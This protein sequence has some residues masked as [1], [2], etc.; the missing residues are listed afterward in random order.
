[1]FSIPSTKTGS[2]KCENSE[3]V[4]ITKWIWIAYVN[5]RAQLIALIAN[6]LL[7]KNV[8]NHAFLNHKLDI[9]N[10]ADIFLLLA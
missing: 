5:M 8:I 10:P 4:S 3:H 7:C 6:E 1:M 2:E 9:Q